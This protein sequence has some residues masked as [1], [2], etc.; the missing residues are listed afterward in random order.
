MQG[1]KIIFLHLLEEMK[2]YYPFYTSYSSNKQLIFQIDCLYL[3]LEL[4]EL[5]ITHLI[6][7][8]LPHAFHLKSP[9]QIVKLNYLASKRNTLK[10]LSNINSR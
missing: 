3:E 1:K 9:V 6:P 8:Q 4:A 10:P 7:G 2:K 5:S